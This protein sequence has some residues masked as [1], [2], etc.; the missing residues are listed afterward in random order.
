M[1]E[2]KKPGKLQSL[3]LTAWFD[4]QKKYDCDVPTKNQIEL[5]SI[6]QAMPFIQILEVV[7]EDD[8][9]IRMAG[10]GLEQRV[11]HS[12]TGRNLSD[13]LEDKQLASM[14]PLMIAG[15]AKT[16]FGFRRGFRNLA[17]ETE[18]SRAST[19]DG[20]T[21]L[22]PLTG[23]DGQINMAITVDEADKGSRQLANTIGKNPCAESTRLQD[24]LWFDF[25]DLGHG[26]PDLSAL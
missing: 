10:S 13:S 14:V 17:R 18:N 19:Y 3:L 9:V 21:L 1:E 22:L 23:L 7:A 11:G 26:L 2:V 16:P 6:A 8:L 15:M 12:L 20:A 5:R 24:T 25:I 4:A